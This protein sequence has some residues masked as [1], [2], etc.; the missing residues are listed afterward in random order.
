MTGKDKA[1]EERL[2]AALRE[3]L[4]KRKAQARAQPVDPEARPKS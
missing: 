2:A 3:N 1:R 4:R